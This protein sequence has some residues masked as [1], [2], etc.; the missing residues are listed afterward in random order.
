MNVLYF[1]LTAILASGATYIAPKLVINYRRKK[2][3]K[4]QHLNELI[5]REVERQIKLIIND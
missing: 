2:R 5:A 1:I 4:K 3:A